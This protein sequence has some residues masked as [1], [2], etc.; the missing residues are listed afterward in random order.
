MIPTIALGQTGIQVSKLAFGTGTNG[1]GHGSDQTRL[2]MEAF[3]DLLVYGYERGITFWDCADQY[4]SHPHAGE[5]IRRVGRRNV[6]L[7]TKTC[8]SDEKETEKDVERFLA[9]A[10]TDHLDIVLL[11][12]MMGADWPIK[13]AGAMKALAAAKQKGQIRA[14]GVSC[15]DFAAL[16]AASTSPWTDVVEARINYQ[17]CSMDGPV[18]D[19]VAVLRSMFARGKGVNAMKL[20]GAGK[21]VADAHRAVSYARTL[22][23]VHAVIV[24]MKSRQEIDVNVG[25]FEA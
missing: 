12:C 13:R 21:L 3:T 15:H 5:A 17:G 6:I 22:D 10:G 19:V 20:L 9:E 14:H 23:C 8:A 7:T 1:W 18:P 24:G 4:G 16:Q 25:I 2:G 11:H